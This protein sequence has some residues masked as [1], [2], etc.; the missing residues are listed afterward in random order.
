MNIR[1]KRFKISASD[2]VIQLDVIQFKIMVQ[3]IMVQNLRELTHAGVNLC[4]SLLT[5]R[6]LSHACV[7]IKSIFFYTCVS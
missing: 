1:P 7:K 4:V 5:Q 3:L 6:D 2:D